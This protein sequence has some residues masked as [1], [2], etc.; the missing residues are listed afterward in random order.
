MI[1]KDSEE[2]KSFV[3]EVIKAIKDIDTGNLLD[4]ISFKST[5]CFFAQSLDII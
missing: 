4:A 1:V 3:K 5:V 2:E